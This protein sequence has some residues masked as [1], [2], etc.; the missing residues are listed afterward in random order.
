MFAR[1]VVGW[2][3][4]PTRAGVALQ[5]IQSAVKLRAPKQGILLHSD[6]GS[7]YTSL[8]MQLYMQKC[9]IKRSFSCIGNC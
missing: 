3:I 4:H 2:A 7:E 9:S 5:A 1:R 8:D 6:R